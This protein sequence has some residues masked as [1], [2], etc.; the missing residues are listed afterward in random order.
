MTASELA[1]GYAAGAQ[2]CGQ[3][4]DEESF[5]FV[6]GRNLLVGAVF[7]IDGQQV[8]ELSWV[9]RAREG[10]PNP[11]IISQ[12]DV[13]A[14]LRECLARCWRKPLHGAAGC[15]VSRT[16]ARPPWRASAMDR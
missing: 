9:N 5:R 16:P 10:P 6:D 7:R 3:L 8:A 4:H 14:S 13:E 15:S 2:P 1:G 12:D 11:M